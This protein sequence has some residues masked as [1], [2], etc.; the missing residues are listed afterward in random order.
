M[1]KDLSRTSWFDRIFS[2]EGVLA[3][4]CF[5]I[6][7]VFLAIYV[8]S[9]NI[10]SSVSMTVYAGSGFLFKGFP[11]G[12]TNFI[13]IAQDDSEEPQLDN[14]TNEKEFFRSKAEV[15]AWFGGE[16]F[17]DAVEEFPKTIEARTHDVKL[18]FWVSNPELSWHQ[19]WKRVN[20]MKPPRL[21]GS[22]S[23]PITNLW[24]Q[25]MPPHKGAVF[26]TT[27]NSST[28]DLYEWK[29]PLTTDD[30]RRASVVK[31][32]TDSETS[33]HFES[34]LDAVAYGTPISA[35]AK[36]GGSVFFPILVDAE[37]FRGLHPEFKRRRNLRLRAT[38]ASMDNNI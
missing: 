12:S 23:T 29:L 17:F 1:A 13:Q 10:S 37:D 30:T 2:V 22:D 31:D 16:R 5:T 32:T 34:I 11:G 9:R 25:D 3:F 7:V 21:F 15:D 35:W 36:W 20:Y 6:V 33:G 26:L 27:V 18:G 28:G 19:M 14:M 24:L 4:L 38:L 8:R